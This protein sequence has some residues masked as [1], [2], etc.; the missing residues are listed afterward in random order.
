MRLARLPWLLLPGAALRARVQPVA[1]SNLAEAVVALLHAQPPLQLDCVG[2]V[3]LTLAQFVASL[4]E[5]MDLSAART[6]ALPESL[7]RLSARCG[8]YLPF[9]PWCSETLALLQQDNV[10]EAG[11]FSALLRHPAIPPQDLVAHTW[12]G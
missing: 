6:M 11:A 5:Q 2:P 10:G 7:S 3:P 9:Q 12:I 1:V 4:R 8:D